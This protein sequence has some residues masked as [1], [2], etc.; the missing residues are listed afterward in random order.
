MLQDIARTGQRPPIG[1][2]E[3]QAA[4]RDLVY[5]R[6]AVVVLGEQPHEGPLRET[7]TDLL[8][9]AP[10]EVGGVWLWDVRDLP[11]PARN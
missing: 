9:R 2:T 7:L 1:D 5:W 3:R 11:V 6:A 8:G 10:Q 4:V